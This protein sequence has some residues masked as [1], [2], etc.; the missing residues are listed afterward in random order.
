[1]FGIMPSA[2]HSKLRPECAE[3]LGNSLDQ[4][5]RRSSCF[6]GP[7]PAAKRNSELNVGQL[8]DRGNI[9]LMPHEY[10]TSTRVMSD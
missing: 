3:T 8:A 9:R 10:P 4:R 7:V 2:D 1:M 6:S 5:W